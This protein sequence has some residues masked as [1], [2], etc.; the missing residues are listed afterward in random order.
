[1]EQKKVYDKEFKIHVVKLGREIGI[2]KA[3]KEWG[4]NIDTPHGWNKR[5][6]DVR[7]DLGPSVLTC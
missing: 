6:K 1:M 4:I 3:A 7:L 5:A 2:S